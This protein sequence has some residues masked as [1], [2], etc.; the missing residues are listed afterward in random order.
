[1]GDL[2]LRFDSGRLWV[3]LLWDGDR[4]GEVGWRLEGE[5]VV[6]LFLGY[7]IDLASLLLLSL[8]TALLFDIVLRE[9]LVNVGYYYS[10]CG[11]IPIILF[12]IAGRI[13]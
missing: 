8:L 9:R 7:F 4:R 10:S 6:L 13:C 1:M 5:W 12:F 2:M 3:E 11:R